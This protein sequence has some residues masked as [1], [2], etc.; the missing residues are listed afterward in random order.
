MYSLFLKETSTRS[1]PAKNYHR[2][3]SITCSAEDI[4]ELCSD[5]RAEVDNIAKW[6]RQNKLSLNTDKTE[7]MVV[8][9]KRQRNCIHGP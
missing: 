9:H 4:G 2:V 3:T 8:G 5:L 1:V 7:Y 6:L